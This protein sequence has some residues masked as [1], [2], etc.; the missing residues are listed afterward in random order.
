LAKR[1]LRSVADLDEFKKKKGEVAD[2][3]N[4]GGGTIPR[5]RI[6][7]WILTAFVHFIPKSFFLL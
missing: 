4:P 1:V 6:S 3:D 7:D 2:I 5:A